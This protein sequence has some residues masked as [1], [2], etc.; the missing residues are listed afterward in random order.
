MSLND[1]LSNA[2]STIMNAER[3]GKKECLIRPSSNMIKK[4]LELMQTNGYIGGFTESKERKEEITVNLLKQI[5]KCNSIKPRFSVNSEEF[6][7][8]E[9]RFLPAKDFGIL[10]ISTSKGLMTHNEAKKKSIGGRLIAFC[11]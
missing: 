4:V 6:E 2:L 7:K 10:I 9:N 5:N 3:V 11:Y 1:S 8:F